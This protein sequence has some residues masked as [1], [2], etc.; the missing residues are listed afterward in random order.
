MFRRYSLI[1]AALGLLLSANLSIT[2]DL[3]F[4]KSYMCC[5]SSALK[6]CTLRQHGRVAA[7]DCSLSEVS[8][9]LP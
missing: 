6:Q 4:I 8:C 2:I 9:D 5:L 3:E 7:D 1:I